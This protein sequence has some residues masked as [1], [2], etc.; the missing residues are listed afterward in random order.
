MFISDAFAQSAAPVGAGASALGTIIQLVFIILIF[1]LLLIR[2][3]QKRIKQHEAEV[4]AIKKGNK[5]ITGGGLYATVTKV[6]ED[7]V[8][9]E[10]AKGVEVKINRYT[11][12]EVLNDATAEV[13]TVK[14][15]KNSKTK[16]VGK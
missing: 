2:P 8:Y 6:E 1:Y 15:T 5:I 10:I 16:T 9:A 3:Q 13:K 12:R 11:I 14:T 4:N 7:G